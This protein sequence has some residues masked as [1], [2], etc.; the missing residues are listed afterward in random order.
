MCE[1][2]IKVNNRE[3]K[4]RKIY[5]VM[6]CDRFPF[7]ISAQKKRLDKKVKEY[8]QISPSLWKVGKFR[9][10]GSLR[11]SNEQE[12]IKIDQFPRETK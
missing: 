3:W 8:M 9:S 12:V 11:G 1:A 10:L 4:P 7:P 6:W 2:G 5:Q